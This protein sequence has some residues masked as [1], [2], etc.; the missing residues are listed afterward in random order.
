MSQLTKPVVLALALGL[1]QGAYAQDTTAT[2]DAA[3]PTA[4]STSP[5]APAAESAAPATA[6]TAPAAEGAATKDAAAAP[7]A[8]E[9]NTYV[10][11]NL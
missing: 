7:Q 3:A 8:P 2:P 1:A 10:K 6:P 11:A 9:N 4:D 5:A